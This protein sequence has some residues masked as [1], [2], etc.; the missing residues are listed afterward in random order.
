MNSEQTIGVGVACRFAATVGMKFRERLILAST[1]CR[2]WSFQIVQ[3]VAFLAN[4]KDTPSLS[5]KEPKRIEPFGLWLILVHEHP[6]CVGRLD[7][8]Q[9]WIGSH[10]CVVVKSILK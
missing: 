4:S 5:S 10:C 7:L 9:I 1:L 8:A 6:K 2:F 3:Y